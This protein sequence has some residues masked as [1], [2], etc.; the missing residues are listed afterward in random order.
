MSIQATTID[1]AIGN[2]KVAVRIVSDNRGELNSN[3]ARA[4]AIQMGAKH[5]GKCGFNSWG[6]S[7]VLDQQGK[8]YKE[9][10]LIKGAMHQ[11]ALYFQDII[12][13]ASL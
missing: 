11:G 12:V 5:L 2:Q 8:P 6:D 13:M 9:E 10:D 7:G 4:L 3:E 1:T